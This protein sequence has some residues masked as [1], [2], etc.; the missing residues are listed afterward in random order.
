MV[1][2]ANRDPHTTIQA[3]FSLTWG[4][5]AMLVLGDLAPEAFSAEA[6]SNQKIRDI[7]SIISVK[8]DP[9]LG[10][11]GIRS[12]ILN[13]TIENKTYQA[14]VDRVIGDPGLPMTSN[15]VIAK[16]LRYSIPSLGE[17]AAHDWVTKIV[18]SS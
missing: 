1:Y 3:Q 14:F 5:A 12:A 17:K 4:V 2:C 9:A 16:F 7:E 13:L 15:Q 18:H 8:S 11:D 10:K 6:L